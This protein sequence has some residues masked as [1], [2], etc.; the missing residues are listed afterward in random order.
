MAQYQSFPSVAGDS[1]TFEK[2]KSLLLP[3]FAGRSFLDV[4]CN[5]GFFC[6][7]AKFQ[8][9]SRVLGIDHSAAFLGRARIRFPDCEFRCQDW[10]P[11]PD[12]QFDVILLASALHYAEDQA[13]LLS[14]LVERLTPD[15]VLVLELGIASAPGSEWVRV[16]RGIDERDFPTMAK[17]R[18]VLADYAWKWMGRSVSQAGDPVP[19]HVIHVMR[20]RPVAYLLMQPPGYG[21]SSIADKLF[22]PAGIQVVSGD[23]QLSLIAA[24]KITASAELAEIIR[25]DYSP[26][27][28]DQVVQRIFDGNVGVSLV[29][30]WIS[31]G[32]R[33]DFAVDA[34]VPESYHP[35]V[36]QR[37]QERGYVPVTLCWDKIGLHPVPAAA[38]DT[39][40]EAFYMSMTHQEESSAPSGPLIGHV[41]FRGFVDEV[42]VEGGQLRVRGWTVGPDGGPPRSLGVRIGDREFLVD[43]FDRQ[44]RPDVQ[45]HLALAHGLVGYAFV[46]DDTGVST[47]E[48][49]SGRFEVFVPGGDNIPLAAP[50]Q[51][52]LRE[53]SAGDDR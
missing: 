31:A 49:L 4:G 10:E 52:M 38:L 2:L 22:G 48:E 39:Q 41:G 40:A 20:R 29:D 11:L 44:L 17:L 47:V 3:D 12:E 8:G 18:E 53:A 23:Q 14:R 1:N 25:R 43:R 28:L 6:G 27:R 9:A 24:D 19:R 7:F 45:R 15:G 16:K 30:A 26:F 37:L 42:S 21:K 35:I 13:T 32:G 50:V 5:E 46:L 33:G 34:Y 51:Q 36:R